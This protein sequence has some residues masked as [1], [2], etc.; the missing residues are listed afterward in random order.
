M[1]KFKVSSLLTSLV[2]L[3]GI[4]TPIRAERLPAQ[5]SQERLP[6]RLSEPV[7]TIVA[8]LESYIPEYMREQNIPGVGIA[9]ISVWSLRA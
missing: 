2:F 3:I 9:L 5:A 1:T 4:A 8:D 7:E 6:L